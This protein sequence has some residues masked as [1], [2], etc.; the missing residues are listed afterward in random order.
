MSL[1]LEPNMDSSKA[2]VLNV[3]GARPSEIWSKLVEPAMNE[4][5]PWTAIRG[6]IEQYY[7]RRAESRWKN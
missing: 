4:R 6:K 1:D 7:E 3:D 2:H 5:N